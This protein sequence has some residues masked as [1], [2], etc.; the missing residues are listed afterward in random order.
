MKSRD[1]ALRSFDSAADATTVDEAAA[2]ELFAVVDLW[3]CSLR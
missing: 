2:D 3:R 1:A